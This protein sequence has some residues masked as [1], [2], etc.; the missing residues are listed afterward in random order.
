MTRYAVGAVK[1]TVARCSSIIPI[2]LGGLACSRS[3]AAAPKRN[4]KTASPPQ[5]KGKGR[6]RA[7]DE[8][9][10]R[11]DVRHLLGRAIGDNQQIAVKVH[12]RLGIA[13]R[14]RG[15]TQ[16]RHIVATRPGGVIADRLFQRG[17]V[18]VGVV[19]CGAVKACNHGQKG[20]IP[21][22]QGQFLDQTGAAQRMGGFGLVDHLGQFARPQHRHGVDHHRPALV[23]ASQQATMAGLFADRISTRFPGLIP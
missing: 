3:A 12:G 19:I 20:A 7:A 6:G 2:R 14:P 23:A 15:E 16:Q 22:A 17:A 13:G 5:P 10:R 4:G 18:K 21:R 9:I 11:R 8:H 1:Q